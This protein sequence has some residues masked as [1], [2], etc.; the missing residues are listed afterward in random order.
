V[1][2]FLAGFSL[3]TEDDLAARAS[4]AQRA[5]RLGQLYGDARFWVGQEESLE[6]KYRL[7]PSPAVVQA[8]RRALESSPDPDTSPHDDPSSNRTPATHAE[9]VPA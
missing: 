7:E 6:R 5:T 9:P 4:A 8:F 1:L 2:C 3:L